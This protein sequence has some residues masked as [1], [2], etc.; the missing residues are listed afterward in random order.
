MR[1]SW[2]GRKLAPPDLGPRL[3]ATLG[4]LRPPL[5]LV[6]AILLIG[7]SSPASSWRPDADQDGRAGAST[8][9]LRPTEHPRLPAALEGYWLVPPATW[10]PTQSA[11]VRKAMTNLGLAFSR[12]KD[13][14]YAAALPLIQDAVLA[15]TP[16]GGWA[17]V[18][19]GRTELGLGRFDQAKRTFQMLRRQAP[20]GALAEIAALGEAEAL[21]GLRD[22]AAAAAVYAALAAKNPADPADML[23][24]LARTAAAAG[25]RRQALEAWARLYY[26]YPAT[27]Q[28][29]EASRTLARSTRPP[30][31]PGSVTAAREL[32]R[33]EALFARRQYSD[34]RSAFE[35]LAK[36][37]KGDSRA[38]AQLRVAECDVHL[39]RYRQAVRALRPLLNS[40]TRRVEAEYYY[41]SAIRG[42]GQHGEYAKLARRLVERHPST[43]WAERALDELASH[44]IIIDEDDKAAGVFREVLSRYPSSDIAQRA[45]WKAGWWAYRRRAFPEAAEAFEGT[46]A[47]FPRS[48]Y[49]PALLYWSGRAREHLGQRETAIARYQLAVTDYGNLY[50]GRQ[51]AA[52]LGN[53]RVPVRVV[54][55]AE[56]FTGAEAA[57]RPMPATLDAELFGWL[58]RAGAYEPALMELE[59][60]RRTGE[61]SRTTETTRAWLYS[62]SG[63]R[64]TGTTI[65]RRTYPHFM[66]D[67]GEGL[68]EEILKVIYPLDYWPLISKYCTARGLDPYLIAA[69]M[70]QESAFDPTIRSSANAVGLMQLLPRTA[71]LWA[72]KLGIR[73]S[74]SR[75]TDPEFSVRVG[76]AHFADL[77]KQFG[78]E[79]FA[80]AGYNAGEH[81]VSAWKAERPGMSADEFIDDIPFPETQNYVKRILGSAEDYRR[82]YAGQ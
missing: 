57:R 8:A 11:A 48:D 18:A 32:A 58:V 31:V 7:L 30:I 73:Y 1:P 63:D 66:A 16:L 61:P 9:E 40:G 43:P 13:G 56:R 72:R 49:R 2:E 4:G 59:F 12:I 17:A 24:R 80:L 35:A 28:G 25:D 38:L 33:A 55:P 81:R 51:A 3:H 46:A 42:S 76:C 75:L 64:R 44:Y 19:R 21:E 10:Q 54:P 5:L 74:A 53:L 79:H 47:A 6:A 70:A 36:I 23:G 62:Q 78:G 26:E 14:T 71:R 77:L 65:M 15:A 27:D 34:A 29:K 52:R 41:L 39:R 82:L 67:G 68:P 20:G 37:E 60:A 22:H 50:Y 45:G 69:L